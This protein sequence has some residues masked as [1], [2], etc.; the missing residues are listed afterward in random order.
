MITEGRLMDLEEDGRHAMPMRAELRELAAAYRSRIPGLK[1]TKGD[2]GVWLH[3][4]APGGKRAALSINCL[5]AQRGEIV[6]SA[7]IEWADAQEP[8]T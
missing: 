3:F 7:M 1:I 8:A 2:D 5:A 6:G 4:E